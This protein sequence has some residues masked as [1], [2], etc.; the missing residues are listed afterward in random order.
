MC[1]SAPLKRRNGMSSRESASCNNVTAALILVLDS[2]RPLARYVAYTR[3]W[4]CRRRRP[5]GAMSRDMAKF[6]EPSST[7]GKRWQC[8]SINLYSRNPPTEPMPV[9]PYGICS[10]A[11][12]HY[13][14]T[15]GYR[16]SDSISFQSM[17]RPEIPEKNVEFDRVVPFIA[18]AHFHK[19]LF[20]PRS[21]RDQSTAQRSCLCARERG[22]TTS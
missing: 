18:A 1:T 19:S 5:C 9:L 14:S 7:P 10:H 2:H 6:F 17:P 13:F 15:R 4:L 11:D 21:V 12:L 20:S 3:R 22:A 8:K 16:Q